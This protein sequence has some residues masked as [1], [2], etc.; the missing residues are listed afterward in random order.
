MCVELRMCQ[1]S[2]LDTKLLECRDVVLLQKSLLFKF[3]QILVFGS[4]LSS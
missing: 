1:L 3:S 4:I 2:L